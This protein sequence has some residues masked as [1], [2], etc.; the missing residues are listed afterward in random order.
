MSAENNI[1]FLQAQQKDGGSAEEEEY[2]VSLASSCAALT[3]S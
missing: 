2:S 1:S 3:F